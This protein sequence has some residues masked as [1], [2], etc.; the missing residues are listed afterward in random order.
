MIYGHTKSASPLLPSRIFIIH[1]HD[2]R[3]MAN[4]AHVS[5]VLHLYPSHHGSVWLCG[6]NKEDE[7]GPPCIYSSMAL[8]LW[9]GNKSEP[10]F[11]KVYEAQES[12]PPAYI[13]WRACTTNRVI[14][15][16][17]QAGNRFLGSLKVYKYGHCYGARNR[18]WN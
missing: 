16:A 3:T 5:V 18:V 12:T 10:V 2:N 17:C 1:W 8:A 9:V 11:V 13:A 6:T 14:V 15:S 4:G 7:R